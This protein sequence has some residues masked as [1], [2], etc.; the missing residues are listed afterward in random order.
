MAKIGVIHY[1]FPGFDFEQFLRYCV[2]T[3]YGYTELALGDVWDEKDPAAR[4]EKRAEAVRRQMDKLGLKVSALS[5]GNDFLV[6]GEEAMAAQARRMERVAKLAKA[7]GT[8]VLRTEGGWPKEGMQE[9]RWAPLIEEGLKRCVEFAPKLDI[10]FALDNHGI[11]TNNGD[12]QVAIFRA[13]DSPHVGANM[14]TMNY[15]WAGHDLVLC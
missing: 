9:S 13:V 5:A 6:A 10:Y 14:D 3:G 15:R 11:V 8:S 1:N 4:P 2:E 12:R 7:L